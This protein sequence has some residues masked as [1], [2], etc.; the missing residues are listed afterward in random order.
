[1]NC[2]DPETSPYKDKVIPAAFWC[3]DHQDA[4]GSLLRRIVPRESLQDKRAFAQWMVEVDEPSQLL[5]GFILFSE[6]CKSRL[7][8]MAPED[9]HAAS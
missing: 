3:F 5:N 2:K 9:I 8:L 4:H 7:L 1:M 6:I